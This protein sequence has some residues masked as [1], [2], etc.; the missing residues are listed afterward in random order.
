MLNS[1]FNSK[2]SLL[3]FIKVLEEEAIDQASK[4]DKIRFGNTVNKKRKRE[5]YLSNNEMEP[6]VP[7]SHHTFNP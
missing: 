4:L 1:K 6:Q 7:L 2:Q 3:S 5:V